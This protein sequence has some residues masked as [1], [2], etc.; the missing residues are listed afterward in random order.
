MT[1]K[2]LDDYY[3]K[4]KARLNTQFDKSLHISK[5][6]LLE[7]FSEMELEEI[8]MQMR[9]EFEK[10]IPEI[11]Y[12]GGKKNSF[13]SML[14][15]G[16]IMLSFF[17]ILEKK[18][19][20]YHE[21]GEF[22][23]RLYEK[24]NKRRVEKLE[25]AGQTPIDQFFNPT[26]INY[27]KNLAKTTQLRKYPDDWVMEYV[28]GDGKTFDYGLNFTE[29]ANYKFFK[30]LGAEIYVPFLCLADFAQANVYEFGFTRTQTIGNGDPLCDHRFLKKGTTPRA[31]PPE[32]LKEL[33]MK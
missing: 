32:T 7:R 6:I 17:R 16:A 20:T 11:P 12:I 33:K 9:N 1:V 24:I 22:S 30:K 8:F 15:D 21:I 29:C 10:L 5:D 31:W 14:V 26:Y 4:N 3:I 23:Y 2:I 18:G 27:C 25:K 19:M 13:T 28:E